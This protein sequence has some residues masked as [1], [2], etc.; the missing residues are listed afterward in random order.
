VTGS[1]LARPDLALAVL[2]AG[3]LALGA[4]LAG[5]VLARRRTRRLLG[6]AAVPGP[7]SRG[8]ALLAAAG[9]VLALALLG[10]RFGERTLRVPASGVD[11]VLLFDVS[12]SMRARDVAPSR[13]ERARSLA[14]DVLAGLGA[15]DRAAL[16]AFAGRGVLL[17]PLTPDREALRAL[18]PAIDETLLAEGGS[19]LDEGV[20][21]ALRAFRP[22]S[23]RPRL[24]L[25][26]SDGEDPEGRADVALPA[27]AALGARVVAVLLGS[28]TGAQVPVQGTPLRD[29]S[30][31][32]VVSRADPA[33][34]RALADPTGGRVFESDRFGAVPAPAVVAALRRDAAHSGEGFVE[35]RVPR[36][37]AAALALLAFALL[38]AEAFAARRPRSD[39]QARLAPAP[40]RRGRHR[41]AAVLGAAAVLLVAASP[42]EE[43]AALEGRV[44]SAP[45]DAVALVELGLARARAGEL[46]EA[47]RAFFAGAVRARDPGLGADAYYDLGVTRIERGDLEGA[48]DA[49]FDAIALAPGDR[50]AQYN[51]EWTLRTLAELRAGESG[52]EREREHPSKPRRG[53]ETPPEAPPAD[54]GGDDRAAPAPQAEGAPAELPRPSEGA[55]RNPVQLDAEA[56]RRWLEA[57]GDDPAR[58]LHA[59][60]RS[61][62]PGA[63]RRRDEGPRW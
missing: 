17:T 36:S 32:V 25:L 41:A 16:A 37:A 52:E 46:D 23:P 15:G 43:R 60:A 7:W 12:R 26:L 8:D 4:L 42:A 48:R 49:F 10:P 14:G 34:L 30:G 18:L 1:D 45:E 61:A 31:R 56:A 38:L 21:A 58:A 44:R 19:R 40:P 47:E 11:V 33:R 27:L 55:H 22:E 28:E 9:A 2:A 51:L 57:V 6:A 50:K 13:L 29:A 62:Q 24:L 54:A 59:A 3:A 20:R 63:P 5:R 53:G 39:P 35:R